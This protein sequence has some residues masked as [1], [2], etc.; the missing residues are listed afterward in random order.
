MEKNPPEDYKYTLLE[1]I[2]EEDEGESYV[3]PT[4]RRFD[5]CIDWYYSIYDYFSHAK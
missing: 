4:P 2:F 5:V 1:P 3:P